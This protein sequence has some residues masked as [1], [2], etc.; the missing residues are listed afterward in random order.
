MNPL[1]YENAQKA[2]CIGYWYP[3]IAKDLLS[4]FHYE[5]LTYGFISGA[6]VTY[7]LYFTQSLVKRRSQVNVVSNSTAS[8]R[9]SI[10]SNN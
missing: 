6:P 7:L 5:S 9:D 1:M 4:L 8:L 2:H 3:L 10:F